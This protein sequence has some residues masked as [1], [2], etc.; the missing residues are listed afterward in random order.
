MKDL[1]QEI[2]KALEYKKLWY[3]EGF[4]H[5]LINKHNY[6]FNYDFW[7]GKEVAQIFN[8]NEMIGILHAKFPLGFIRRDFIEAFED[9]NF[10][11]IV[12]VDDLEKAE[13]SV[14]KQ[15]M[16]K[17]APEI[18]WLSDDEVVNSKAFSVLD[19]GYATN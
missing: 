2:T 18:T 16:K 8:G 11:H 9:L 7:A 12:K 5:Y 17:I 10:Y 4:I 1:I 14:D 15:E 6:N 3:T 13:W 19:F